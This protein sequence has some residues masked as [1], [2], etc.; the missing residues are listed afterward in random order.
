[1]PCV[2]YSHMQITPV[3]ASDLQKLPDLLLVMLF[4]FMTKSYNMFVSLFV[5]MVAGTL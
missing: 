1:M 5:Q 2:N 3:S 4:L